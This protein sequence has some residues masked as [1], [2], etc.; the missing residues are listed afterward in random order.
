MLFG[1][2][3]DAPKYSDLTVRVEGHPILRHRVVIAPHS[4]PLDAMWQGAPP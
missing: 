2:L 4:E 3:F 1:A